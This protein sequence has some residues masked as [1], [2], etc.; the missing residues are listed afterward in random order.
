MVD[1]EKNLKIDNFAS[2]FRTFIFSQ[3]EYAIG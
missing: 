2:T 3:K 1:K